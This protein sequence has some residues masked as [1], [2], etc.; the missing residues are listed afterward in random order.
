MVLGCDERSAISEK[1][2]RLMSTIAVVVQL[3]TGR[4]GQPQKAFVIRTD[5]VV[6]GGDIAD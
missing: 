6:D 1:A 2:K 5:S 4:P 3:T